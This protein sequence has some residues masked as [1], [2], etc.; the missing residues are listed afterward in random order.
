MMTKIK[1]LFV[2][3]LFLTFLNS[4]VSIASNKKYFE[5]R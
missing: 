2:L 4:G 3:I 1:I 5:N